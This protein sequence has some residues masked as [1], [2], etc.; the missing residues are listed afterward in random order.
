MFPQV[1]IVIKHAMTWDSDND[2]M[3]ENSGYPDQ[4]YDAWVM[5]GTR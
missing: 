1:I 3:I 5:S 4:T 2:G